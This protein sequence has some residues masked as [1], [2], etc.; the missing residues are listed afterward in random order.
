MTAETAPGQARA[1]TAGP[2]GPEPTREARP[3]GLPDRVVRYG[4]WL[5]VAA[6]CLGDRRFQA[7]V[8]TGAIGVHALFSVIKNNQARPVRRAIHWYNV[9]GQ[10]H[11]AKV[12]HHE[13][14]A[15]KPG[16]R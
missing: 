4:I 5:A 10:I 7:S 14:P 16:K 12:L 8:I 9:E 1:M 11:D 2:A 6:R 3:P 13:R 15:V